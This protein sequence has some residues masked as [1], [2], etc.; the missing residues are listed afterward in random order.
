MALSHNYQ[1]LAN[2]LCLTYNVNKLLRSEDA[3]LLSGM[4]KHSILSTLWNACA[5]AEA[6]VGAK[7]RPS[8]VKH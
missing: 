7:A 3:V 6:T 8:P 4:E 1:N 5:E 2:L